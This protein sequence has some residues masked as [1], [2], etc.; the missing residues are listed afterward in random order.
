MVSIG[1]DLAQFINRHGV[2]SMVLTPSRL[3]TLTG[4]SFP[5]LDFIG[6]GGEQ[7]T[8]SVLNNWSRYTTSLPLLCRGLTCII[9]IPVL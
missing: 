4:F 5:S 7:L 1:S 3:A 8:P 2:T 6:S 9:V